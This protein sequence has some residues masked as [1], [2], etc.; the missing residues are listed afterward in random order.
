MDLINNNPLG[1]QTGRRYRRVSNAAERYVNNIERR[2]GSTLNRNNRWNS[3]AD[4]QVSRSTY[5][6]L[7]NG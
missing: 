7:S 5:M 2:V 4:I 3:R 6:G 1:Q